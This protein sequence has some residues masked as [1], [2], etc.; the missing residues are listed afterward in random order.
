MFELAE[1][2]AKRV[3]RVDGRDSHQIRSVL[4]VEDIQ[5]LERNVDKHV[6]RDDH[7]GTGDTAERTR[8]DDLFCLWDAGKEPHLQTDGRFDTLLFGQCS[9]LFSFLESI[10]K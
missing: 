5:I 8:I 7:R 10:A 3:Q 4:G 2:V 9:E 1:K 6:G